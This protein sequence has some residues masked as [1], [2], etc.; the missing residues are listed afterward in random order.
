MSENII[1]IIF[2][3]VFFARK[4]IKIIFVFI[5]RNLFLILTHQNNLK[6]LKKINLK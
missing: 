1:V 2:F 4:N 6:T 5:F 3:K